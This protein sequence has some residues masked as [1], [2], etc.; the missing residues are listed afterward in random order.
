LSNN[1][2][3]HFFYGYVIVMLSFVVSLLTWGM[4]GSFGVFFSPISSEFGWSRAIISGGTSLS[5]FLIG[6]FSI[7]TGRLTDRFGPRGLVIIYGLILGAGYILL[8]RVSTLWQFY[9]IYGLAIGLG[10][11]V[12]DASLLPTTARWFVKNRGIMSGVVKAGTGAGI[13][14]I[15]LISTWIIVSHD[16]RYAY[17]IMGVVI[18]VGIVTCGLFLRHD[19]VDKGLLPYGISENESAKSKVNRD[20][21]LKQALRTKQMWIACGIYFVVWYCTQ[22]IMIHIVPHSLDLKLSVAAAA[23]IISA[24]GV[25]S[26]VGRLAIGWTLDRIG[27]RR[28]LT[29]AL[30]VLTVSMIWLLFANQSWMLYLFVPVYGVAHG[31]FF[32]LMSP[33]IAELFGMKSQ[34]SILGV[35]MFLGQIGGAVGPFIAGRIFD[36]TDSYQIAFIILLVIGVVGLLLSL[37][38][39]PASIPEDIRVRTT[40]AVDKKY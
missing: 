12:A 35:M 3:S 10:T 1:N 4:Y 30:S 38:L 14:I 17:S 25:S 28:A 11:S 9:L 33:L 13:F 39:K 24:I 32:V 21:T 16:W 31:A 34:G 40:S 5:F 37:S 20:F 8:A 15:P 29:I 27:S 36:V 2:N 19:P 7:F 6:L 26:M 22:T 18:A 23:A